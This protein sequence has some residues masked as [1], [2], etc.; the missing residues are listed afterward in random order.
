MDSGL[1]DGQP[2]FGILVISVLFEMLSDIKGLLDQMVE[3]L[4]DLG[5]QALLSEESLDFLSS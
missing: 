5:G 2:V 3:V 4:G 1:L